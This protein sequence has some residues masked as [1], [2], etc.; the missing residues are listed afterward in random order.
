LSFRSSAVTRRLSS[1]RRRSSECP[2]EESSA[3]AAR[4]RFGELFRLISFQEQ[5]GTAAI[6]SRAIAGG[7]KGKLVVSMPGS[8]AA[9]ELALTRILLPELRHA[10][11]EL[12]R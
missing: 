10:L 4:A 8:A 2:D 12:S 3:A 9:V 1:Y 7:A 6:L 11:R 5:V